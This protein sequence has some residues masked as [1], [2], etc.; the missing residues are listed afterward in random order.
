MHLVDGAGH[1]SADWIPLHSLLHAALRK[2]AS[3]VAPGVGAVLHELL[4]IPA[5]GAKQINETT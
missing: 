4:T 5:R 3:V 2:H 1:M